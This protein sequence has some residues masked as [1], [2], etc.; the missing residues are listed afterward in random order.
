MVKRTVPIRVISLILLSACGAL[1][2]KRPSTDLL[3]GVQF[4][5]SRSPGVQPQEMRTWSSLP[6]APS[7]VQPP[8]QAERFHA[9]VNETSSTLALGAESLSPGVRETVMGYATARPP[10]SSNALYQAVLIQK[11]SSAFFGKYLYP[12]LLNP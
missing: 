1:C 12:P 6:D 11:E 5:A 8:T 7:S 10:P 3:E 9:F 2:Q 4:D